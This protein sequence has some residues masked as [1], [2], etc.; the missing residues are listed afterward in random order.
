MKFKSYCERDPYS[1]LDFYSSLNR[2]DPGVLCVEAELRNK[3]TKCVRLYARKVQVSINS[4]L[5]F[6][7]SLIN[8]HLST[9][10]LSK[11]DLKLLLKTL[12][13]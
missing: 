13:C 2:F 8:C 7:W 1:F 12:C 5:Q 3:E 11:V 10:C 6:E 9:P 4:V